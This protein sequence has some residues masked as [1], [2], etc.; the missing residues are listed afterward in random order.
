MCKIYRLLKTLFCKC[1]TEFEKMEVYKAKYQNP[2]SARIADRG[3]KGFLSS[4]RSWRGEV[5][6][7]HPSMTGL[8][9]G[10]KLYGDILIIFSACLEKSSLLNTDNLKILEEELAYF[11]KKTGYRFNYDGSYLLQFRIALA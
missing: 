8:M 3:V 1:Q 9:Y 2:S 7:V 10:E 5:E 4:Y 6:L 11:D